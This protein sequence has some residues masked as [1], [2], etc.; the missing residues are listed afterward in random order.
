ME[1]FAYLIC[2]LH[3]MRDICLF[4]PLFLSEEHV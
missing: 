1:N 2:M 3:D 4:S